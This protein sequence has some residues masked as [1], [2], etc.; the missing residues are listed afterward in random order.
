MFRFIKQRFI[1]S[2][3]VCTIGSFGQSL[4]SK[5]KGPIKC[6]T[7]NNWPCPFKATLLIQT[8]REN[9]FYQ[10]TISANKCGRSCNTI[11]DPYA[12][13]FVPNTVKNINIKVFNSISVNRTRFLVQHEPCE[14]RCVLNESVCNLKQK[15]NRYQCR[16]ECKGLDDWGSCE[17]D[18]MWNPSTC[19]CQC[20]KACKIG[21]YL[22]TKICF[23]E[24][25]LIRKLVLE[26]KYEVLDTTE[27]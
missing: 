5:L 6:L 9:I 26:C 21:E 19:D 4:V 24:K 25:R 18:Y 14:H 7:L 27:T 11:D 23:C 3:S 10:V 2:L 16:C 20:N 17:K 22:D 13:A 15:W 8:F 1:G 12:R